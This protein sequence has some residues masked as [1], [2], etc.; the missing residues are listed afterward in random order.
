M[1]KIQT[2]LKI[3]E[4][5]KDDFAVFCKKAKLTMSELTEKLWK[6][7][8]KTHTAKGKKQ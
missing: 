7:H 3:E 1:T 5:V 4:T 2:T 6:I 8:I